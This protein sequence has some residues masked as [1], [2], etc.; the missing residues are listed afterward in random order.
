[1]PGCRWTNV[2]SP[3]ASAPPST[4]P[5]TTPEPAPRSGGPLQA[6]ARHPV[7][8]VL[9]LWAVLVGPIVADLSAQGAPRFAMTGAIVDDGRLEIDDYLI[10]VDYAEK[11]GHIYS[12]KAPGQEFLVI[13][14][15]VVSQ[16]VGADAAI[17]PRVSENMSLWWIT[18]WSSGL[19][20]L[21]LIA[22]MAGA[23]RRRG[24]RP[25]VAVLAG[26]GF[27]TMLLP[28]SSTLYGHVM[29]AFLG[30]AAWCLLDAG[31]GEAGDRA[32]WRPLAAGAVVG[33]G[34]TV[35]YQVALVAA[36]VLG[37]LLVRRRGGDALRFVAGAVPFALLLM[38]YQW[39]TTGSPLRSGYQGKDVHGGSTLFITGIP[40]PDTLAHVLFGSRGMFLFTP[41]VL[42]GLIGLVRRWRRDRDDG[43][44]VSLWVCGLFILLQA[45]WV[46]PWGGDGPGPRYVTP[47][48]PFLA[49]GLADLW[50]DVSPIV[51]R[52]CLGL[53][54]L[55]MGLATSTDH[56]MGDGSV[57]IGTHLRNL[58]NLGPEPDKGPVPSLFTIGLGDAGL[59]VHLVVAGAI[60]LGV[61]ALLARRDGRPAR[62]RRR[63][64]STPDRRRLRRAPDGGE[65]VARGTLGTWSNVLPPARSPTAPAATSSR[66]P[67]AG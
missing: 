9:L 52:V 5:V 34:V 67:T 26:M 23:I 53:S 59:V 15:Y 18:L 20:W 14:V 11:D 56:L 64:P 22:L 8:T 32:G 37:V 41:V 10:G 55:S 47:M 12:D 42:L 58:L 1:M 31:D 54:I 66:T 7:L 13:P 63:P 61:G 17:V 35:E 21:G 43:A 6:L 46:N 2:A 39:V 19:P 62:R 33:L 60:V 16:L 38:T 36:V 29:A 30:Y 28:F 48:L 65:G 45:G 4:T 57:L 51:R 44:L 25:T 40:R 27:G 50:P 24:M 49:I 3:V